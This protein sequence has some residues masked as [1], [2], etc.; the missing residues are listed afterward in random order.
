M[1]NKKFDYIKFKVDI[2]NNE[3]S[4]LEDYLLANTDKINVNSL[5][6]LKEKLVILADRLAKIEENYS[7]VEKSE[8]KKKEKDI[9]LFTQPTDILEYNR[10]IIKQI[11]EINYII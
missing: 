2:I 8:E 9:T 5:T 6:N 3:L 11:Y 7:T 10:N 1:E 4:F